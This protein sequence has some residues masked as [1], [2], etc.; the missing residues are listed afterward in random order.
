MPDLQCDLE[1]NQDTTLAVTTQ[2]LLLWSQDDY[3][4]QSSV[5]EFLF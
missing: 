5:L 3:Q 1:P 4:Y 2:E